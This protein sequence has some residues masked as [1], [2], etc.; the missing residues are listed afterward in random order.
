MTTNEPIAVKTEDY[1]DTHID[2]FIIY[3]DD[4]TSFTMTNDGTG[5]DEYYSFHIDNEAVKAGVQHK[6][7]VHAKN[8][9]GIIG[10]GYALYFTPVFAP[11]KPDYLT[12]TYTVY[13]NTQLNINADASYFGYAGDYDYVGPEPNPIFNGR[14]LNSYRFWLEKYNLGGT[15]GEWK[16]CTSYYNKTTA[17]FY[18]EVCCKCYLEYEMAPEEYN[19]D[20][21]YYSYQYDYRVCCQ[22]GNKVEDDI[23]KA[24]GGLSDDKR[25]DS[26]KIPGSY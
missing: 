25:T 21:G 22:S 9:N 26:F 8:D 12:Y 3:V 6:F 24:Y 19:E 11:Q 7:T 20:N 1:S 14:T 15:L 5:S 4:I 18:E 23:N 16:K 2:K 10:N 13:K 17:D